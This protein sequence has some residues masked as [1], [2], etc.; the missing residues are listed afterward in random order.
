MTTATKPRTLAK[1]GLLA[2][3]RRLTNQGLPRAEIIEKLE[4][5]LGIGLTGQFL[6]D[7][8]DAVIA[9]LAIAPDVT[10]PKMVQARKDFQS[11]E[12]YA[13]EYDHVAATQ[14]KH[15]AQ[16]LDEPIR[17]VRMQ[18]L[19]AEKKRRREVADRAADDWL[20][21]QRE[22]LVFDRARERFPEALSD[23][24]DWEVT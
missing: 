21:I 2:L 3:L 22:R 6:T 18:A 17:V 8:V 12:R 15:I 24:A 13:T 4:P 1:G 10:R 9:A 16:L 20:Q 23:F 5:V 19:E 7:T 14:A 11:R